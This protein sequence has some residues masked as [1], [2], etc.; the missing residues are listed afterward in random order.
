MRIVG[1][2]DEVVGAH[3]VHD[4]DRRLLVHVERDVALT[5]EVF[6][7]QHRELVL[8]ARAELLPLVV[9]PPE[10]PVEQPAGP[11]RKAQRSR[12]WRSGMPPGGMLPV[13][14]I[15]STGLRM[16]CAIGWK[17]AWPT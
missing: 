10:P 3:L 16:A 13:A 15:S 17:F 14:P 4:V 8:A 9:E 7:R 12:G 2:D 5:L 11:S 6:A 1:R